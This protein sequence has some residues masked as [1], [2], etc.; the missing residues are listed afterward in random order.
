MNRTKAERLAFTKRYVDK[1]ERL[2]KAHVLH[3]EDIIEFY[4]R[5]QWKNHSFCNTG[6]CDCCKNP[7]RA[8]WNPV[9]KLGTM[10]E[11]RNYESFKAQLQDIL[12]N[13]DT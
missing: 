4:R 12:N 9:S 10:Q 8:K 11:R 6:G 13:D 3:V 7:R 1:Q 5:G 2:Y